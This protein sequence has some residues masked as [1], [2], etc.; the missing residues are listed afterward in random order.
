LR[1]PRRLVAAAL[2]AALLPAAAGAQDDA[3]ATE[4]TGELPLTAPM[5]EVASKLAFEYCPLNI[6]GS[7]TAWGNWN[8]EQLGF[9]D[10]FLDRPEPGFDDTLMM[11]TAHRFDGVVSFAGRPLNGCEVIVTGDNRMA[12]REVLRA[13]LLTLKGF[14][15]DPGKSGPNVEAYVGTVAN[16]PLTIKLIDN[17]GETPEVILQLA[18]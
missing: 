13:R 1:L 15:P 2:S 7:F 9:T 4:D 6:Y 17:P 11:V 10:E 12:V 16:A 5:T 3:A 18:L 8:L 14:K